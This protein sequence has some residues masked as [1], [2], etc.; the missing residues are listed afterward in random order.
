MPALG[1]NGNKCHLRNREKFRPVQDHISWGT[2]KCSIQESAVK[3]GG[4][5][6]KINGSQGWKVTGDHRGRNWRM[7]VIPSTGSQ[8]GWDNLVETRSMKHCCEKIDGW[9]KWEKQGSSLSSYQGVG[10]FF[11]CLFVFPTAEK[12]SSEPE[13]VSLCE[14]N[15]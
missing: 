13:E 6:R 7:V 3:H 2:R 1:S 15:P 5:S 11:V 8:V 9:R 10:S 12:G 14:T 4:N